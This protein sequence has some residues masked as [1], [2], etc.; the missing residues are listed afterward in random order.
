MDEC[1]EH[2]VTIST[3]RQY[4]APV[5]LAPQA[6]QAYSAAHC[7]L[8]LDL[9]CEISCWIAYCGRCV[10]SVHGVCAVGFGVPVLSVHLWVR[11]SRIAV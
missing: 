11:Y 10:A 7:P 9:Q 6:V 4:T 3:C 5:V 1:Y 8:R 2:P